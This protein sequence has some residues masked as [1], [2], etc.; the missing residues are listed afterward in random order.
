VVAL[1]QGEDLKMFFQP[2]R[3]VMPVV[4]RAEQSMQQ[5]YRPALSGFF[6]MKLHCGAK[7]SPEFWRR[8]SRLV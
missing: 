1:V 5:N 8:R 4:R 3:D 6:E 2:Q 7:N